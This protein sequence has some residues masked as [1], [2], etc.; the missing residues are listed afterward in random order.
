MIRNIM[1]PTK[2]GKYNH[3]TPVLYGEMN[4]RLGKAKLNSPL[5]IL[6]SAASSSIVLGKHTQKLRKKIPIRS[7]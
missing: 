2:N 1:N 7:I 4:S 6:D 3:Y 5:I